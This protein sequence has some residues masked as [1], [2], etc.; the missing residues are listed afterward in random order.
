MADPH[1]EHPADLDRESWLRIELAMV[2]DEVAVMV[3]AG[4]YQAAMAGRRIALQLRSELDEIHKDRPDVFDPVSAD[5]VVGE[6][7]RLPDWVFRHPD[8]I[9]RVHACQ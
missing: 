9:A 7:L 8:V 1:V 4:S 5:H 2:Q 6:V 3:D